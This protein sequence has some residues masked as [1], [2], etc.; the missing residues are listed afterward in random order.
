M[1]VSSCIRIHRDV[2]RGSTYV[3]DCRYGARTSV[4]IPGVRCRFRR[5]AVGDRRDMA[6]QVGHTRVAEERDFPLI[7]EIEA[8]ISR[9]APDL[10][11]GSGTPDHAYETVLVVGEPPVGF[12]HIS[13]V[14]GRFSLE[15]IAVRPDQARQGA[16]HGAGARRRR[17]R[18][19]SRW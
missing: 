4:W 17:V 15:R 6:E 5:D 8:A 12:A 10:R 3:P 2:W 1:Q 7:Q 13:E 11:D 18:R 9:L 14:D 16:W 19:R